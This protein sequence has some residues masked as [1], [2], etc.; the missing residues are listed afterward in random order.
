VPAISL[1]FL[2]WGPDEER[3]NARIA[4]LGLQKQVRFLGAGGPAEVAR[5]MKLSQCLLIPSLS[6]SIPLVYGEALQARIPLIVT[7]VGDMGALTS[8]FKLGSVVPP[9]D[10]RG[11]TGAMVSMA[12][13][14]P[15]PGFSERMEVLLRDLDP[16]AAA[17]T[18]LTA[19]S[20]GRNTN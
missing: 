7:D 13:D 12:S 6:D 15:S 19:V 17:D 14:G 11:M 1:S 5:A 10:V 9:G 18:L 20:A 4:E 2:G 3:L 8:A 16:G